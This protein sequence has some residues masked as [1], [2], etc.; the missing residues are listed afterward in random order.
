MMA[1]GNEELA[2]GLHH[3]AQH[4]A[5]PAQ[6]RSDQF[7]DDVVGLGID[8][9]SIVEHDHETS[10]NDEQDG[11]DH[12]PEQ[13]L[14]QSQPYSYP[15]PS[16][17]T[18]PSP[19]RSQT[20]SEGRIRTRSGRISR[21]NDSPLS[22]IKGSNSRV[23]KSPRSKKK[24]GGNGI[25]R[26]SAPLSELTKE[27][28][29]PVKDIEAWVNRAMEDRIQESN[30]R[31][32]HIARPM[33]SFMLY[34]SAYAERTKDWCKQNNHQ[35]VS[36]VAGES[37]PMESDELRDQFNEWARVERDNHARTFPDYKFSPSKSKLAK[38]REWEEEEDNAGFGDPDGEYLPS[39]RPAKMPRSDAQTSPYQSSSPYMVDQYTYRG[40][41][42][43]YGQA[44]ISA[45]QPRPLPAA[46]VNPYAERY[47]HQPVPVPS[48]QYISHLDEMRMRAV[49]TPESLYQAEGPVGLPSQSQHEQR[50]WGH[51][52][53][54]A[55]HPA[56]VVSQRPQAH[57]YQDPATAHYNYTMQPSDLHFEATYPTYAQQGESSFADPWN[58]DPSLMGTS[59]TDGFYKSVLD[60][61]DPFEN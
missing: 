12:V 23:S 56:P 46:M 52:T 50:Q 10:T 49:A 60:S 58:L 22:S 21:R 20:A 15:D 36:S 41:Q 43:Q 2:F 7:D 11:Y 47:Y 38:R 35:V 24:K 5:G 33:N 39:R 27:S 40:A 31:K 51:M 16:T 34:R 3:I 1:L 4:N 8:F 32:G 48:T 55:Y 61:V 54:A 13:S 26:I 45:Q 42:D 19:S 37:W 9:V 30:K 6:P 28:K 25:S 44:W 17:L 59:D 29:I 53:P 57:M 18:P 14:Y